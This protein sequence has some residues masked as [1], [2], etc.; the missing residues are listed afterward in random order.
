MFI[1]PSWRILTIGDGDLSFSRALFTAY[2]PK[3][4]TASIFDSQATLQSKYGD[5][6]AVALRAL[7]CNVLT[8]FDVT[9]P[10]S[11][12]GLDLQP[13]QFDLVIF[14]FPLLPAFD[15]RQQ[16]LAQCDGISVNTL[17]RQ[18]LRTFLINSL[19]YFLAPNG[20]QLC[21]ITSKD[22]KPYREWNIENSIYRNTKMQY[23]GSSIFD[24]KQFPGYRVRNVD[25][26]KHVKDTAGTTYVWSPKQQRQLEALL[27]PAQYQ[28]PNYC[29][30]CRAG[31]FGNQQQYAEHSQSKKHQL[32]MEFE[33]QWEYSLALEKVS[34]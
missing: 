25:R 17:N 30:P 26:D 34:S 27:Q 29:T 23:L 18:L 4:L 12:S 20:P 33:Q 14:Q 13:G 31:P 22:V 1:D 32:M 15:D 16:Y 3:Q 28:G 6:H 5:E 8:G 21:Y 19:E 2:Q 9:Q 11:W 7:G 24:I 10:A